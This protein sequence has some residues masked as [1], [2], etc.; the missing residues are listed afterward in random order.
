MA[1]VEVK[2]PVGKRPT[3]ESYLDFHV[4]EYLN[5]MSRIANNGIEIPG[6]WDFTAPGTFSR[7]KYSEPPGVLEVSAKIPDRPAVRGIFGDELPEVSDY[8]QLV[9]R[10]PATS[11]VKT[12]YDTENPFDFATEYEA[13]VT[14]N[15]VTTALTAYSKLKTLAEANGEDNSEHAAYFFK[16][17]GS[18][19]KN[20]EKV[21]SLRTNITPEIAAIVATRKSHVEIF[22][23]REMQ[24]FITPTLGAYENSGPFANRAMDWN[25][26]LV[27]LRYIMTANLSLEKKLLGFARKQWLAYKFKLVPAE[28]PALVGAYFLPRDYTAKGFMTSG[29][30]L[31]LLADA[32]AHYAGTSALELKASLIKTADEVK[33]N[34]SSAVV[35]QLS[36]PRINFVDPLTA[37]PVTMDIGSEIKTRRSLRGK[38]TT[39]MWKVHLG[40][41]Y[42]VTYTLEAWLEQNW[43]DRRVAN[44]REVIDLYQAQGAYGLKT[45]TATRLVDN[46]PYVVYDTSLVICRITRCSGQI[47][48]RLFGEYVL[49]LGHPPEDEA[50]AA[51]SRIIYRMS[52]R[53]RVQ[54]ALIDHLSRAFAQIHAREFRRQSNKLK[55][56]VSTLPRLRASIQQIVREKAEYWSGHYKQRE[57][58]WKDRYDRRKSKRNLEMLVRY[59]W[60]AKWFKNLSVAMP[61]VDTVRVFMPPQKEVEE[62]TSAFTNFCLHRKLKPPDKLPE[63]DPIA[64]S[65][66][67]D[68]F[69]AGT[70]Y[71]AVPF[72]EVLME[73]RER[74][75]M[76]E[77]DVGQILAQALAPEG[78]SAADD[79]TLISREEEIVP[80]SWDDLLKHPPRAPDDNKSGTTVLVQTQLSYEEK[81]R[82]ASQEPSEAKATLSSILPDDMWGDLLDMVSGPGM[83]GY[84]VGDVDPVAEWDYELQ[85]GLSE[86]ILD[87]L[88]NGLGNPKV[89]RSEAN[90]YYGALKEA[91]NELARDGLL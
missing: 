16:M 2:V 63:H 38:L 32:F 77:S 14:K 52:V 61:D 10:A 76:T 12:G 37:I 68:E 75:K 44:L 53:S 6:L 27:A 72:S 19:V 7:A 24:A 36:E 5:I 86:R 54:V 59:Q 88:R 80:D 89:P 8:P 29:V 78:I 39:E 4:Q 15:P 23:N 71:D 62:I 73:A 79:E 47:A 58:L 64:L 70:T 84:V 43:N 66:T 91:Y 11:D 20:D 22:A 42:Y 87:L 83:T 82:I 3:G 28:F 48:T 9:Q 33:V 81:D 46:F 90:K 1:T 18:D 67:I 55:L 17:W 25:R 65:V 34:I 69:L 41:D 26:I 30:S 74:V 51:P 13:D 57:A 31:D 50:E 35:S 85:L 40:F 45:D 56:Q 49:N 60:Y 21:P